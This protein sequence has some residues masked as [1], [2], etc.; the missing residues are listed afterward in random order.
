[1]TSFPRFLPLSRSRRRE[2]LLLLLLL[3][4][5]KIELGILVVVVVFGFFFFVVFGIVIVIVGCLTGLFLDVVVVVFCYIFCDIHIIALN[6]L[7]HDGNEQMVAKVYGEQLAEPRETRADDD[8][9]SDDEQD[10]SKRSKRLRPIQRVVNIPVR[11]VRGS[12]RKVKTN[13]KKDVR[14]AKHE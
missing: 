6:S 14:K 1:M 10:E 7:S 8:V 12:H 9:Q 3:L 13:R 4:L 2:W 11:L 5:L